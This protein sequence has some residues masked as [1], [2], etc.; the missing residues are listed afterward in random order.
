M[1]LPRT[2]V[3]TWKTRNICTRNQQYFHSQQPPIRA[4]ATALRSWAPPPG[5][6]SASTGMLTI[7]PRHIATLPGI[8]SPNQCLDADSPPPSSSKER[9]LDDGLPRVRPGRPDPPVAR[10]SDS[11]FVR[12]LRA[13]N[14]RSHN[15]CSLSES[16]HHN[17]IIASTSACAI[18]L[19]QIDTV[20][21]S[22]FLPNTTLLIRPL[23]PGRPTVRAPL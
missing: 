19:T 11:C 3:Q 7:C 15:L 18:F 4:V 21:P 1:H 14:H 10:S 9:L 2:C 13:Q 6:E 17:H 16:P 5:G 8:G 12:P 23:L 22:V 20:H